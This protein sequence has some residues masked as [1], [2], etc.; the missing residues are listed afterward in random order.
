MR[1]FAIEIRW[2]IQF[3]IISIVWMILEKSLGW[4]DAQ[5]GRQLIYTNLFGFVAVALYILAIRDKKKNYYHGQ[6]TWKQAFLSGTIMTV[7]IA[8]LSPMINTVIYNFVTPGFFDH[9][10]AHRVAQKYQTKEQA[11]AYFNL[12]SYIVL[13]LFD[14]LSKGILT[15]A[16]IAL[17]VKNQKQSQ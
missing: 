16:V 5:I 9:M 7:I 11:E 4:H 15:A 1:K 8:I 2:A 3:S 14:I 10:V 17:F 13:G 12:H 6:M